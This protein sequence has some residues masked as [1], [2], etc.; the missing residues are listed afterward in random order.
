[1]T[2]V[3]PGER[4]RSLAP[5][6]IAGAVL[7]LVL[8]FI[9]SRLVGGEPSPDSPAGFVGA[10]GVVT[11]E[12]LPTQVPL[13]PSRT[14]SPASTPSPSP[15]PTPTPAPTAAPDAFA[16]GF[17]AE[18]VACRSLA[19]DRCRDE[20]G[21]LSS[22]GSFTALMRF[23]NIVAGD[24]VAISLTGPA[25]YGGAPYTMQ[26]GGDGYYYSQFSLGGAPDGD[27][28]LVATRNGSEV[29]RTAL[30]VR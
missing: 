10:G 8:G 9:G 13:V 30:T 22:G 7:L 4:L 11:E 21:A 25:T 19:G 20:I 1:M 3:P 27:Y 28:V 29:A 26:G 23:S 17:S 16:G 5:L 15:T 18:V 2:T 12:A 14:A 24:E 6:L